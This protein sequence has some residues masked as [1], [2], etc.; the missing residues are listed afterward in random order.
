MERPTK[1]LNAYR[2]NTHVCVRITSSGARVSSP[3][4]RVNWDLFN[5]REQPFQPSTS[6][7]KNAVTCERTQMTLLRSNVRRFLLFRFYKHS[8]THAV[9][10]QGTTSVAV[11]AVKLS[12]IYVN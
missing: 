3:E 10:S 2:V 12:F 6:Y 9:V 11:L 1:N 7:N 5:R 4:S 8:R